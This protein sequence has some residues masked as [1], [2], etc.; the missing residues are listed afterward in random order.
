MGGCSGAVLAQER[1]L[2]LSKV[3]GTVLHIY[4]QRCHTL[5]WIRFRKVLPHLYL[6]VDRQIEHQNEIFPEHPFEIG[7]R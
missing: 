1:A 4:A 5:V 7:F 2:R 3:R 6:S